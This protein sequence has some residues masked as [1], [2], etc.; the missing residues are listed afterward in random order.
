MTASRPLPKEKGR[1]LPRLHKRHGSSGH[2]EDSEHLWAVSYADLLMVLVAFFVV[3][4]SF[5]TEKQRASGLQAIALGMQGK[6]VNAGSIIENNS[7]KEIGL[8]KRE[9]ENSGASKV[10]INGDQML[11][12]L[13]DNIFELRGFKLTN[14]T[15]ERLMMIYKVIQPFERDLD[16]VVMGHSDSVKFAKIQNEYLGNN[17][18]LSSLRA[19][20]ALQYMLAQGFPQ[21]QISAQGAA[22]GIRNSRTLSIK[23]TWKEA[24]RK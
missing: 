17:F 18:D 2:A 3:F 21:E 8:L 14:E 11:L 23:I 22:D 10:A 1:T 24:R 20:R 16:V 15:Q 13:P 4:F 9:L 19:L 7:P 5:D 6:E 12:M